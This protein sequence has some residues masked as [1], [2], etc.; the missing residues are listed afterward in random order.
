MPWQLGEIGGLSSSLIK[1]MRAVISWPGL[2]RH[3]GA[4]RSGV[5]AGRAGGALEHAKLVQEVSAGIN[6]AKTVT[7]TITRHD[8]VFPPCSSS[9]RCFHSVLVRADRYSSFEFTVR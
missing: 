5:H 4:P 2:R 7:A 3:Q 9:Q 6:D 8:H 1:E